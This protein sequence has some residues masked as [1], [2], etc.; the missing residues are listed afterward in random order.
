MLSLA[1]LTNALRLYFI[2]E[3]TLEWTGTV[4]FNLDVV[5]AFG[6]CGEQ[7]VLVFKLPWYWRLIC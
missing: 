6:C 3:L 7:Q 4:K 5:D 1:N 2:G